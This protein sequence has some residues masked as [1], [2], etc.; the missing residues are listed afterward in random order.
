MK[1]SYSRSVTMEAVCLRGA[2][3]ERTEETVS[4]RD[5]NSAVCQFCGAGLAAWCSFRVPVYRP[6][7]RAQDE[8]PKE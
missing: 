6:K 1:A 2:C 8:K 3:Y 5:F 7:Q 4:T